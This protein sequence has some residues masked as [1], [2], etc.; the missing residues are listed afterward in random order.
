MTNSCPDHR[1]YNVVVLST[2]INVGSESELDES[3]LELAV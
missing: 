2:K 3:T 1:G